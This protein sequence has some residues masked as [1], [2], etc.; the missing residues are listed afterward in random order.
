MKSIMV[1]GANTYGNSKTNADQYLVKLR[2]VKGGDEISIAFSFDKP[3]EG[4]GIGGSRGSVRSVSVTLPAKTAQALSHALQ[5]ALSETAS[6]DVEF[7]IEE[8]G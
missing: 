1:Y 5:L 4:R 3:A 6:T 7:R 8:Q 2:R